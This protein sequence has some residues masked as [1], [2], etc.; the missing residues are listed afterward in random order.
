MRGARDTV[1]FDK[2]LPIACL[3]TLASCRLTPTPAP[4][5]VQGTHEEISAIAGEW[6]GQYW[7]KETGR[8]G[9]IRF[10]MPEHADTG[11][12]EVEITFSPALTLTLEAAAAD[13]IKDDLGDEES[14]AKPCTVLNIRVVRVEHDRVRGTMVPYWDPDCDCRTRTVFEGKV[15]GNRI[16]GTFTSQRESSDRR[17]ITGRWHVDR[18]G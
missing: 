1:S 4:V 15:S 17:L 2:R 10:A 5:P 14:A 7:S 9:V 13:P 6:S 11:H 18:K 3:F 12:G 8:H 16:A